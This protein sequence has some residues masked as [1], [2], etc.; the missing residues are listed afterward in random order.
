MPNESYKC[1]NCGFV[2]AAEAKF[3]RSCGKALGDTCSGC[4][5]ILDEDA[6]FCGNCG[7]KLH[8]SCPHCGVS[9]N[10]G[11]TYCPDCGTN[12]ES[13]DLAMEH[14]ERG[15][16]HL[17]AG[18]YGLAI[19]AYR[20]ALQY[21][22][23]SCDVQE[24]IQKAE[25]LSR[26][27]DELVSQADRFFDEKEYEEA[28]RLYRQALD[29]GLRSKE[30][31]HILSSIPE[32]IDERDFGEFTLEW[33]DLMKSSQPGQALAL[34]MDNVS[35]FGRNRLSEYI[36]RAKEKDDDQHVDTNLRSAEEAFGKGNYNT[37]LKHV[38][39]VLNKQPESVAAIQLRSAAEKALTIRNRKRA[40]MTLAIL[41]FAAVVT[42]VVVLIA[43]H[44]SSQRE[45]A[46]YSEAKQLGEPESYLS[47]YPEG[48]Y[49]REM[50]FVQDS[51]ETISYNELARDGDIQNLETFLNRYPNGRYAGDVKIRIQE[52]NDK[53]EQ[54][55]YAKAKSTNTKTAYLSYLDKFPDGKNSQPARK[56]IADEA[57]QSAYKEASSINTVE[58]LR[59]YL[60]QYPNARHSDE[61]RSRLADL[62]ELTAFQI[63]TS[64]SSVASYKEFLSKFPAGR[65]SDEARKRMSTITIPCM[66]CSQ[67]GK[68]PKCGGKG[69][70]VESNYI[71]GHWETCPVCK[72][73]MRSSHSNWCYYCYKKGPNYTT[74]GKVWV[75][76]KSTEHTVTCSE[77]RGTGKCIECGGLGHTYAHE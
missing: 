22:P 39:Q 56:W 51:L 67:T 14:L 34:A 31:D 29:S 6:Q 48:R 61:I 69:S 54:A 60:A 49:S 8:S 35:R 28:D 41:A 4:G 7:R 70:W 37:V 76:G 55:A 66:H 19:E 25:N 18:E 52:I 75:Y 46:V 43:Q 45:V 21:V 3:C 20:S 63:A 71:E 62:P 72:G 23:N 30:I 50:R 64:Q 58:S 32:R 33:S 10:T 2:N 59:E 36:D 13:Y 11:V 12:V 26:A 1:M 73:T 15:N 40:R 9:L 53:A 47:K 38:F 16:E 77:C 65:Y 17:S 42:V 5:A 27:L 74:T 44:Q 24:K 68:C 57:E